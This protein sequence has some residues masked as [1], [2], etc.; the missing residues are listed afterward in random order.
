M[1]VAL[2]LPSGERLMRR[3]RAGDRI[4]DVLDFLRWKQV[5]VQGRVLTA[6]PGRVRHPFPCT[7]GLRACGQFPWE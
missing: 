1:D 2:R 5:E 7:L 6:F 3:F 4:A